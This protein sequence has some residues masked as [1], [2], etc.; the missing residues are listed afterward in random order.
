M[1]AKPNNAKKSARTFGTSQEASREA[2]RS[3]SYLRHEGE[4][5]LQGGGWGDGLMSGVHLNEE[6]NK[7]DKQ[8]YLYKT[9]LT[10]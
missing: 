5:S 10:Q 9:S 3:G 1:L 2:E 8:S 6:R 4:P 7:Q